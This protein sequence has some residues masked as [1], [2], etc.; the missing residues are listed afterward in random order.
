MGEALDEQATLLQTCNVDIQA[1]ETANGLQD[2]ISQ[3]ESGQVSRICDLYGPKP[4]RTTPPTVVKWKNIKGSIT[5]RERI[6]K[7]LVTQFNGDKARFFDFFTVQDTS[8]IRKRK[9]KAEDGQLQAMRKVVEAIPHCMADV[10]SEM[11]K[12]KYLDSSGQFSDELWAH[13]W[14]GK[15]HW[16]VWRQLGKE[17]Y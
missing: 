7:Q 2:V 10:T 1:L 3:V 6:Y 16:E 12:P 13:C 14:G 8:M 9:H 5:K 11:Q 4:G 17:W 15:N